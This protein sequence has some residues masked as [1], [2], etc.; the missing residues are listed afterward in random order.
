MPYLT[1]WDRHKVCFSHI[2]KK[3][4]VNEQLRKRQDVMQ[5][6]VGPKLM[7]S[8]FVSHSFSCDKYMVW[9]IFN[10]FLQSHSLPP[11]R[12][13]RPLPGNQRPQPQRSSIPLPIFLSNRLFSVF[14]AGIFFHK[15]AF[16]APFSIIYFII[17]S[18]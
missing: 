5:I 18:C 14:L 6:H 10:Q 2:N 8:K 16:Q 17:V 9:S 3:S 1:F 4:C 7:T 11:A 13:L 15:I 12:P